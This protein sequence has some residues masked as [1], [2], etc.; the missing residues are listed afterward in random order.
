MITPQEEDRIEDA[1]PLAHEV[2]WTDAD[3]GDQTRTLELTPYWNDQDIDDAG[4]EYPAL[5]LGWEEKG[6]PDENGEILNNLAGWDADDGGS[7]VT[8]T[9]EHPE[10]DTLQVT[11]AVKV[12]YRYEMPAQVRRTELTRRLYTW[13]R[14][15]GPDVLNQEGDNGERPILPEIE[16]PPTP[17]RVERT[18]RSQFSMALK[19]S[20][21]WVET[22]DA[23]DEF[24]TNVSPE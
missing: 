22:V 1:V 24:E 14:E 21:T 13:W 5:V 9:N 11:I 6:Q 17:G 8:K 15:A 4:P 2:T 16:S 7:T 10:V 3:G 18:L 19:H 23:V 20:E 12:G